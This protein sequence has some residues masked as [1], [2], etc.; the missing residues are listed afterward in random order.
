MPQPSHIGPTFTLDAAAVSGDRA[1]LNGAE[2]HHLRDV[3]RLRPGDHL[4]LIESG[5]RRLSAVLESLH[6]TRAWARIL[7]E[8]AAPCTP[9]LILAIGLIKAPRMDFLVEKASELGASEIWPLLTE[10]SV[11]DYPGPTRLSRWRRLATAALK[12]SGGVAAVV[13]APTALTAFLAARPREMVALICQPDGISAGTLLQAA[14]AAGVIVAIG[15]EGDFT[16][17]ERAAAL[18]DGFVAARLGPHRL[19]SETAAL[20][21]LSLAAAALDQRERA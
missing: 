18:A 12:Q 21:A 15:P 7:A 9:P 5:G 4:T 11:S 16:P 20:A 6:S 1:C 19:R 13:R 17:R 14:G 2:L 10:R 3:L 8:L